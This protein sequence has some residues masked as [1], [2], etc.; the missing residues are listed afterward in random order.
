MQ[1]TPP[2]PNGARGRAFARVMPR[3]LRLMLCLLT[4]LLL[5]VSRPAAAMVL[6]PMCGGHGETLTAPPITRNAKDYPLAPSGCD[7]KDDPRFENHAPNP[8]P[9]SAPLVEIVPRLP[10]VRY[11]L[12][13]APYVLVPV[14]SAVAGERPGYGRGIERPPR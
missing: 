8:A 12:P 14:E 2:A 11:G 13:P 4:T 5:F 3:E 6:A 1:K 7:R 9:P 10:P